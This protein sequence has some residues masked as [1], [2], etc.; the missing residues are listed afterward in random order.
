MTRPEFW[1]ASYL[2]TLYTSSN[3]DLARIHADIA[4]TH[5]DEAMG[6]DD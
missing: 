3:N 5:Y 1:L 2:I 4:V 6:T